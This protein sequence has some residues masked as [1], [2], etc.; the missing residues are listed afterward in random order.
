MGEFVHEPCEA[1][2]SEPSFAEPLIEG[3]D[4]FAGAAWL[5]AEPTPTSRLAAT[6]SA[7]ASTAIL[8]V[9]LMVSSL[10]VFSGRYSR[11]VQAEHQ[12]DVKTWHARLSVRSRG[13]CGP[14][15]ASES[16]GE[17]FAR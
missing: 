7:P 9:Q 2:S 14:A 8:L 1:V 13:I 11:S 10:V 6:A 16:R 15:R 4:V 3:S 12:P 5:T 17:T